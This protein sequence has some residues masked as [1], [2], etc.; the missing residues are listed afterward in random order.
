MP[1]QIPALIQDQRYVSVTTFRKSGAG[2]PTPVW[3]GED[4]GK[5]YVMTRSDM[6]KTKRVRNNPRVSVAP[7]SIRGKVKG[8]EFPA[9]AR[10]LPPE[11]HAHA[12]Q[13]INRKYFMARI[14]SPWSRADVFLEISFE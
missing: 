11:D 10:M 8:P 12:R 14:T 1:S 4:N 6:G 2:V 3:F 7:C 5:I 13:T 9:T